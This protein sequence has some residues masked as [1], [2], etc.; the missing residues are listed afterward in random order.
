MKGIAVLSSCVLLAATVTMR[1]SQPVDSFNVVWD[2]PSTESPRLDA[3]G[4][5][6]HRPQRLDDDATATSTSTSARP[7]PGMTTRACSKS[8][9]CASISSRIRSPRARR[10]RQELKLREGGIEIATGGPNLNSSIR[11]WVDA[12]HPVIHIDSRKRH[13]AGSHRLH[14]ALAHESAGTAEA[15]MQRR[16]D[17]PA[18]TADKHAPTII[19]PDTFLARPTRPH[20]LAASQHQVRRPANAGGDPGPDRLS[21]ARSVAPSHFRRRGH[22][23]RRANASTTAPALAARHRR[24]ASASLCSPAIRPRR[25]AGWRT[26]TTPSAAWRPSHSRRAG[27][28]ARTVV[29]RVLGPQLDSRHDRASTPLP[30]GR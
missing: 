15:A 4:Q 8:A 25:S 13:A 30:A 21:T 18:R 1:G 2:S 11:L 12:N 19:E 29:A 5:R 10:F 3:A 17:D 27:G 28:A 7:T 24:I 20:R 14:R 9:R 16:H 23:C 26:W 22:R 6:R